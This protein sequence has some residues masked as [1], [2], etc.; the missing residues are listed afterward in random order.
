[1]WVAAY[2]RRFEAQ[3]EGCAVCKRPQPDELFP[4]FDPLTGQLKGLVCYGCKGLLRYL[5]R[6]QRKG[7]ALPV[8][9]GYHAR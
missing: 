4:D 3:E 2:H 5:R 8:E 9:E 1:M 7:Q 6:L